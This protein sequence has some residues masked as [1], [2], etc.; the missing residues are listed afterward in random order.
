MDTEGRYKVYEDFELH[1]ECVCMHACLVM[2]NSLWPH[3]LQPTSLYGILQTGIQ[4]WVA[5]GS[6]WSED[7]TYV[8]CISCIDRWLLH[9]WAPWE[10]LHVGWTLQTACCVLKMSTVC[11]H[12]FLFTTDSVFPHIK[13]GAFRYLYHFPR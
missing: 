11:L 9:H 7:W 3:G 10:A 1:G 4:K 12:S 8:S 5:R 6:S 13:R 2:S